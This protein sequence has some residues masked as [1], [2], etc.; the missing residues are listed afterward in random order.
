MTLKE[1][2][3][4]IEEQELRDGE[5]YEPREENDAN[6]EDT[7]EEITIQI[8]KVI[9]MNTYFHKHYDQQ[10]ISELNELLV[11]GRIAEKVNAR[12]MTEHI[13][14]ED[15]YVKELSYWR[16]D[17]DTFLIDVSLRL[18]LRVQNDNETDTDFFWLYLEFWFSFDEN[19]E[20]CS[21]ND[22]GL[23][24]NMPAH[25]DCWK[26]DEYLV[27][28]IRR[29][30][31]ETYAVDIW[32]KYIPE[33]VKDPYM[34][35]PRELAKKMGLSVWELKLYKRPNINGIIFFDKGTVSVKAA[36]ND[37]IHDAPEPVEVEVN[38]NTIVL[39]THE[40]GLYDWDL[41]LYHECIHYE[42]HYLFYKLQAMHTSD[43]DRLKKI[44][45]TVKK[46][47]HVTGPT[48]FMEKH[49]GRG[50][51]C[52]MMPQAFM[53]A[54]IA[55]LFN[56]FKQIKRSNGYYPHDGFAFDFIGRE[57]AKEYFLSKARVKARMLQ[58][59]YIAA[60][61][62]LNY[63]DGR[64]IDP[65]AF[66]TTDSPYGRNEY[67]ID[68][69]N[70]ALLYKKNKKFRDLMQSGQFAYVDGHVVYTKN[71]NVRHTQAGARLSAWA[72]AHVDQ[73][74]LRFSKTYT[75]VHKFHDVFGQMNS[76]QALR[77]SIKF[78]DANSN[79]SIKDAHSMKDKIAEEMPMSF[80]SALSYIMKGRVTVDEL[81]NRV[82]I[83]RS[84]IIRLRTE[85]RKSYD[86][87]RVI[88]ICIGLHLPPWLSEILL[89]RAG[90]R[91][92]RYGP[93][94]YYGTILDCFYMDTVNE[95]QQFLRD[96][97]YPELN[98]RDE[99]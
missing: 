55:E 8:P 94:G 6:R 90:L 47:D 89:D 19:E 71:D 97:G 43:V 61:G 36:P 51:Y 17:R 72:N 63:V 68:R 86:I 5:E 60:D 67:V 59:G 44:K 14:P 12:I 81:V 56:Q 1:K 85:E 7:E 11:E 65:F 27:P 9:D 53:H 29:D 42:W 78:L 35:K 83:S 48:Y 58:L 39:N 10:I 76:E 20:E 77:D 28:M 84:T 37:D 50:S 41:D 3:M 31:I 38:A 49:A 25:Y 4:F 22:F 95:V 74:C 88:A 64:Y 45:V 32:E 21:F 99:D 18:E 92:K 46:T 96:N 70:V 66:S 87:D 82:P 52:L 24:G 26:L 73:L 75:G 13:L 40:S 98:L 91:V 57:I 30:E 62:A 34:R 93:K 2:D 80:H 33:A 54:K 16:L 23:L 15:C 69:E 79:L